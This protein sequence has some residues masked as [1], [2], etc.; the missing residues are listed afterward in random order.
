MIELVGGLYD[1]K[2]F[3]RNPEQ[4]V[5]TVGGQGQLRDP[6]LAPD[7]T[8]YLEEGVCSGC[9]VRATPERPKVRRF[10]IAGLLKGECQLCGK[11]VA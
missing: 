4:A 1:G 9:G 7:D 6:P 3:N 5:I 10:V 2:T 11:K 8:R